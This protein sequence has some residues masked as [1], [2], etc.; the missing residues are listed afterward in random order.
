MV[1]L[2]PQTLAEYD[3][4]QRRLI[5][6]LRVA[7]DAARERK[8]VLDHVLLDGPPGLGKTTLA[9]II[10]NEMGGEFQ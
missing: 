8:D 10:A 9:H 3:V 2:R 1:A 6:G 4:G 7:I 5:D